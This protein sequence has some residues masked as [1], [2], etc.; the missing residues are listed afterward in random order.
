MPYVVVNPQVFTQAFTGARSGMLAAKRFY[1][2]ANPSDYAAVSVAAGVWA[3]EFDT[4]WASAAVVDALAMGLIFE[5]SQGVWFE[6]EPPANL[7]LT[8]TAAQVA[9]IIASITEAEAL[10]AANAWTPPPWGGG[11]GGVPDVTQIGAVLTGIGIGPALANSAWIP[12]GGPAITSFAK[13][14]GSLFEV[15]ANDVSPAFTATYNAPASAAQINYTG[16]AGSPLVLAPPFTAGTIA[17]TFTSV[18]NGHS[19]SFQLAATVDATPLTSTLFDTWADALLFDISASGGIVA[20]QGFLDTMRADHGA[21][22]HTAMA[23]TY[24]TGLTVGAGAQFSF[25]A[26]SAFPLVSVTDPNGFV[27]TPSFVGTVAG[28]TNP[29]GVVVSMALYTF[30]GIATGALNPKGYTVS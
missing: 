16:A 23:G 17:H 11:S 5:D 9:A 19:E 1:A 4:Q 2:S 3:Q 7:S 8:Q 12:P 14:H 24:G 25:A 21:F 20:T 26:P 6:R 10:Y 28:Y 15:G 30:G 18:I 29:F 13:T 22:L 27:I